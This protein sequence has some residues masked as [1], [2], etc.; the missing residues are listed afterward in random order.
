MSPPTAPVLVAVIPAHNEE[1]YLP[2]A[3]CSIKAQ[4]NPVSRIVVIADRCTDR[5]ADIA[6]E[7]GCQVVETPASDHL[8]AGV[9][10][11]VLP[12]LLSGLDDT[13]LVL[14]TDADSRICPEFTAVALRRLGTRPEVGAIGGVFYGQDG[15][16]LLGALQRNEYARYAREVGRRGA[17]ATV[18]TGTATVFRVRVLRAVAAARGTRLPGRTGCVYDTGA[19]A[20]DNEITL[21]VRHLGWATLSPRQ[22]RVVTEIMPTW[23]DFVRQRLRWQRGALEPVRRDDR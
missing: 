18:L 12:E 23:G 5:T 2:L 14:I 6:R 11:D 1:A 8:K 15:A 3:I 9:L 20:E 22:C 7:N 4:R 16:G 17:R 13:D 19:L 21:A 10:N